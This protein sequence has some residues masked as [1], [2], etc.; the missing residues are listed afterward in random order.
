MNYPDCYGE[1]EH[2]R[3]LDRLLADIQALDETSLHKLRLHVESETTVDIHELSVEDT[4]GD[5]SSDDGTDDRDESS[6]EY[7]EDTCLIEPNGFHSH[8]EESV[9]CEICQ[10]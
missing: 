10:V 3:A 8:P 7:L 2:I 5:G 9:L 1:A 4:T 6:A